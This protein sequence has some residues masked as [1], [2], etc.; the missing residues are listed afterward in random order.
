MAHKL[1]CW[2]RSQ[3]SSGFYKKMTGKLPEFIKFERTQYKGNKYDV[4]HK[5]GIDGDSKSLGY[6]KTKGKAKKFAQSYM[7]KHDRC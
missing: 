6:F 3:V 1:K 7:K 5:R 4:L 2:V